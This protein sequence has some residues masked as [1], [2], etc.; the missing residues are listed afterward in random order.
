MPE[1]IF[2]TEE[3][4]EVGPD[5]LERLKQSAAE[6]PRGR[7]RLCLH[8][9]TEHCQQEMAIVLCR[10]TYVR[11]HRHIP[12]KSKSYHLIDGEM[13]VY[14]FDDHGHVVRRIDMGPPGSG[15]SFLYRTVSRLWYLP[16]ATT[17]MVVY[18]EVFP[19]PF[20]KDDDV[21]YAAWSP[22]EDDL[23]GAAEYL[24]QLA[25]CSPTN[26]A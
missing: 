19:G 5:M 16:V 18:H 3:I 20:H 21:E 8:T 17:D 2:A 11:P 25:A 13:A 4:V 12:E 15:K 1:A 23:A 7:F 24:G 10:G 26:E 22:K 14:L 6:S 9:S